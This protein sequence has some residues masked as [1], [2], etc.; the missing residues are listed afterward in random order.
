L[1]IVE[2]SPND[3]SKTP[4]GLAALPGTPPAKGKEG[5]F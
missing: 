3:E 5:H 4:E 1:L 2:P